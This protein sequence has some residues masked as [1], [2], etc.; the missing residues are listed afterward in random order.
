M[1]DIEI[2]GHRNSNEEDGLRKNRQL[3]GG[4]RIDEPVLDVTFGE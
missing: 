4:R 3:R 1:D 2:P